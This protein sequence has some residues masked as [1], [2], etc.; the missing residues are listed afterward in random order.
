MKLLFILLFLLA[1]LFSGFITVTIA[2][3]VTIALTVSVLV[4]ISVA[5]AVL[6]LAHVDVVDNGCQF[7]EL[8]LVAQHIDIA[9]A[10]FR[11]YVGTAYIYADVC[12][13][14]DDGGIGHH[15]DGGGIEYHVIVTFF[16]LL[17][18]SSSTVRATSSVGLG[19]TG[20]PGRMSRFGLMSERWIMSVSFT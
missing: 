9:V 12:H 11:G 1:F 18:A 17:M 7:R 20:P 14:A 5:V 15:T 2:V 19:G 16:Q 6:T 10:G 4:T 3:T 13:T 8:M